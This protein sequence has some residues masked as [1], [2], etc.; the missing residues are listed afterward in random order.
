MLHWPKEK[1]GRAKRS[2]KRGNIKRRF[3][4]HNNQSKIDR[5]TINLEDIWT[6]ITEIP[7]LI[8]KH[9]HGK[10]NGLLRPYLQKSKLRPWVIGGRE[11][12]GKILVVM[13]GIKF[14]NQ[15]RYK[16]R[17]FLEISERSIGKTNQRVSKTVTSL[18]MNVNRTFTT[19]NETVNIWN[20]PSS[21]MNSATL[22]GLWVH[23]FKPVSPTRGWSRVSSLQPP[24]STKRNGN[25]ATS[26]HS[27]LFLFRRL[28]QP[29]LRSQCKKTCHC[30]SKGAREDRK[31]ITGTR[32]FIYTKRPR[33]EKTSHENAVY[34]MSVHHS[35][36]ICKNSPNEERATPRKATICITRARGTQISEKQTIRSTFFALAAI[37]C[38]RNT[39][40][41]VV[42]HGT[43]T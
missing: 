17:V 31:I 35:H 22:K 26:W 1:Q 4:S 18:A 42:L 25:E 32:C 14:G 36:T 33:A 16:E 28:I 38:T 21:R 5:Q 7:E 19:C 30:G 15:D 8:K 43:Q 13:N 41:P 37:L 11:D 6:L 40:F 20:G 10:E 24:Q 29:D 3:W 12:L 23:I 39:N 27:F 34:P 2:G 9:N